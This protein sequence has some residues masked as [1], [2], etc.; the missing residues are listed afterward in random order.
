MDLDIIAKGRMVEDA[1]GLE[2]VFGQQLGYPKHLGAQHPDLERVWLWDFPKHRVV[3]EDLGNGWC[4][5]IQI[6]AK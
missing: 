3:T 2:K 5:V 6:E 4:N 1:D